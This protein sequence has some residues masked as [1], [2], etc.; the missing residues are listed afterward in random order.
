MKF[1]GFLVIAAFAV[2]LVAGE[3]PC[4]KGMED[5][6]VVTGAEQ[7]SGVAEG[8]QAL[9]GLEETPDANEAFETEDD[10]FEQNWGGGCNPRSRDWPRCRYGGGRNCF[11]G[12]RFWPRCRGW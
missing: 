7:V 10:G 11:R 2:A 6:N 1:S 9:R 5:A 4:M 12:S 3:R 8:N